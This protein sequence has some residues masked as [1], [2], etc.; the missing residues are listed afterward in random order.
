MRRAIL[1]L[2]LLLS[3]ACDIMGPQ[4]ARVSG[5]RPMEVVPEEYAA[6]YAEAEECLGLRGDFSAV[7][8]FVADDIR[9]KDSGKL[10]MGLWESPDDITILATAV[11]YQRTIR[12]E[13]VHHIL[14]LGDRAHGP[15][16]EKCE[17]VEWYH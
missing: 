1:T 9:R 6:W 13:A 2:T 17:A 4:S 14:Q 16:M 11:T 12:H 8:W 7:R 10:V 5:K 3:A 15:V